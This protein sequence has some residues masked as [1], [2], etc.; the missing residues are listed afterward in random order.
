MYAGNTKLVRY[1]LS[2]IILIIHAFYQLKYY[3]LFTFICNCKRIYN[4]LSNEVRQEQYVVQS[5]NLVQDKNFRK[6]VPIHSIGHFYYRSLCRSC[7]SYQSASTYATWWIYCRQYG[8]KSVNENWVPFL[9][10]TFRKNKKVWWY[11][12]QC[13]VYL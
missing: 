7:F 8:V 12:K 6:C 3:S 1:L 2:H 10:R 13:S 5:G 4:S 11:T 9:W